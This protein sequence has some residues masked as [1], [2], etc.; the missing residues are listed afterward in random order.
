[1]RTALL[2][3]LVVAVLAC[4]SEPPPS[5]GAIGR[6]A[7]CACPGGAQGAQ[8]CGPLGVWSVCVCPDGG[9]L[10][11]GAEVGADGAIGPETGVDAPRADDVSMDGPSCAPGFA[12]C[13]RSAANGCEVDL[14]ASVA[15]C[16]RCGNA[17]AAG[18]NASPTCEAGT[19]RSTCTVGFADCNDTPGCE[20]DI[21]TV[22]N[23][24][25]CGRACPSGGGYR[26]CPASETNRCPRADQP[27]Q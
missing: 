24:G 16:G 20:T 26:C 27:C 9:A 4:G 7:P 6:S 5:C 11:G 8:E 19:C 14:R 12:D 2:L 10:E 25:G 3:A 13:D 18:V 21:T 23:C 22:L 15:H 1:M 17:C